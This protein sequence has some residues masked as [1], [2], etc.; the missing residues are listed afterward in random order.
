MRYTAKINYSIRGGLGKL[1]KYF[2]K[3]NT[4]I[5]E[6]ISYSDNRWSNGNL[7]KTLGFELIN[8]GKSSYHYFKDSTQRFHRYNFTKHKV[9]KL[10]GGDP[11]KD[12]EWS[13]MSRNG[14]DRIWDC[15]SSKWL[16]KINN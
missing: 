8:A 7:Y 2:I 4:H 13:I 3:N 9:L 14:Y 11:K 10:F 16:L 6:I 12:T 15:G 1:L 5:T